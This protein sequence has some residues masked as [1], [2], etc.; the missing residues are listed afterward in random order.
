STEQT[1]GRSAESVAPAA[2]D[3]TEAEAAVP[4]EK[5]SNGETLLVVLIIGFILLGVVG[6]LRLTVLLL[7]R[8]LHATHLALGEMLDG[9]GG[10]LLEYLAAIL[11]LGLLLDLIVTAVHEGGHA[12]GG[13]L[14]GFWF[15]AIHVRPVT[16]RRTP[17]GLRIGRS[18]Y[19]LAGFA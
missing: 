8:D 12:L 13:R 19:A 17:F 4:A 2:V 6:V 15:A 5:L 16:I 9:F 18:P 11:V 14:V 3:Q 7:W 10:N 1:M